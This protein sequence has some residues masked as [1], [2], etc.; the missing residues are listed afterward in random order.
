MTY[1]FVTQLRDTQRI[2]Q[3][4]LLSI[5]RH[6]F[7]IAM[8]QFLQNDHLRKAL[9][10]TAGTTLAEASPQDC[11]WGIGHMANAPEAQQQATWRGTNWLGYILTDIRE[12]LMHNYKIDDS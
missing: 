2:R 7:A 5:K 1:C 12:E 6:I 8:F 4:L 11:I 3:K 9:F 10:D